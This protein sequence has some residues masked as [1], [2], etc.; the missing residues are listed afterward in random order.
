MPRW[1][2]RVRLLLADRAAYPDAVQL[3]D[4]HESRVLI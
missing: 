4:A 3:T 1:L 2:P